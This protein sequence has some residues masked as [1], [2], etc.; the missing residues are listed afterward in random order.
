MRL[1]YL[2][3]AIAFA[4][5]GILFGA[6]NPDAVSVDFYW[7]SVS[8]SLGAALLLAAFVG[9]LLGGLAMLL[10]VVWP[11]QARLRRTR[12]DQAKAP[13]EAAPPAATPEMLPALGVDRS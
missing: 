7:H 11:L 8:I 4:A 13:P 10:G 12:R 3:L 5:L 9:A 6:L 1:L 2:A